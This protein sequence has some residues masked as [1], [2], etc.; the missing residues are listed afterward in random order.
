MKNDPQTHAPD[1]NR[2]SRLAVF[3]AAI[4]S[5]ALLPALPALAQNAPP[6][7][8]LDITAYKINLELHPSDHSLDATT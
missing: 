2:S 3:C 8:T 5:A 4:V 7:Q 1:G 6:R